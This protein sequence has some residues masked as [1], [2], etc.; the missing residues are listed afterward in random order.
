[1]KPRA[2]LPALVAHLMAEE[3]LMG[4]YG[5]VVESFMAEQQARVV[6]MRLAKENAE[7]IVKQ[8]AREYGDAR[9]NEITSSLLEVISGYEA[10]EAT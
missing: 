4:L 9:Q 3:L 5:A 7:G 8:L 6:A 10:A 2:D 1:M